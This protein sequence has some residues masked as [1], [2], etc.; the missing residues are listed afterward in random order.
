MWLISD[1]DTQF[2]SLWFR[3]LCWV[4]GVT[5][6]LSTIYH[7]QTNGQS[8][9]TNQTMEGLL[10]IFCNHQANDWAEWLPVVQYIINS[11]P[12]STTKQ[13][14]YE[15]WMGHVPQVHQAVKD[16]KV[17]DLAKRQRTLESVREEAALA[18]QHAQKSWVKPTN[19]KPY[20]KGDRVWLKAI[21]LYT[22]H[23]TK[24]LGPKRYRPFKVL[25]V[26]RHV[27]FHLKL[28]VHW[29]I[30][31]I[32]HA[33]QLHPYKETEEHGENFMEPPPDLIEGE[34]EWEVEKILDMRTWRSQNWY[35]IH[36]KGYSSAHN[37]WEPW[38]NIKAPL[39]MAEFKKRSTQEKRDA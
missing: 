16:P 34:P 24:K 20:Q 19:Y 26:V 6:N 15:L 39:L 4:L 18:M 10:Q 31:N 33:K 9:W 23:P 22:T 11:W 25:E 21:H 14:P 29:R 3:E 36:W 17:L 5:Q 37:S 30:H 27:N 28:P 38:E 12:S 2:T 1:Q 13:V 35:L 8:E 7:P 32:F